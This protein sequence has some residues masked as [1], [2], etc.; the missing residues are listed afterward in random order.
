MTVYSYLRTSTA[1]QLNGI[2]AQRTAIAARYPVTV[3]SVEHAS[4]KS[5]T[6]R[7]I[8]T[9]LVDS[10]KEGDTL[11]VSK[12]DRFARSV[13]DAV[14]TADNLM[15]RGVNLVVLDMDLD[16]GTPIGKLVFSVLA[17]VAEFERS[18]ISSRTKDGLAAVKASGKQLG[19][20]SGVDCEWV[21][22]L[23]SDYGMSMREI[24]ER[25]GYSKSAVHRCLSR[26]GLS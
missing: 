8:F 2:D 18:M 13:A 15:S 6:G 11:V 7:P 26:E 14:E 19:R 22:R 24:S 5:L 25:T 21:T 4:G 20:P 10:L 23:R 9:A 12:L 3:E 16:F 17:S 1:D